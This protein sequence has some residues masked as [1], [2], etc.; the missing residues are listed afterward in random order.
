MREP[1]RVR[2]TLEALRALGVQIAIDDFGTGYSS[3]SY[4]K[5]LPVDVLKIDRS[6]VSDLPA[7]GA[8]AAIVAATIELSTGSGSRS[9]RKASK[10]PSSS[11]SWRSSA[12][13]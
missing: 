10:P 5:D 12:A 4:L 13:I 6:F 8:G 11:S 3:L 1:A 7:S 9:S 2:R